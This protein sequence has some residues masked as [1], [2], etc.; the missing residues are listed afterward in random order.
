MFARAHSEFVLIGSK[1]GRA[2]AGAAA[3]AELGRGR[4]EGRGRVLEGGRN[5][6]QAWAGSVEGGRDVSAASAAVESVSAVSA[7][8]AEFLTT[9]SQGMCTPVCRTCSKYLPEKVCTKV[10]S[11][12]QKRIAS[13]DRKRTAMRMALWA[14]IGSGTRS[15]GGPGEK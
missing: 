4:A 12:G 15:L 6:R 7:V 11:T 3:G 5:A 9:F 1:V 13:L 14:A 2:A 10:C 8:S